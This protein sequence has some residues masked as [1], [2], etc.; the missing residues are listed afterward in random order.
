MLRTGTLQPAAAARA[1]G[2]AATAQRAQRRMRWSLGCATRQLPGL[3]QQTL[4]QRAAAILLVPHCNMLQWATMGYFPAPGVTTSGRRGA[5]RR[6]KRAAPQNP[7]QPAAVRSHVPAHWVALSKS[8]KG[9]QRLRRAAMGQRRMR[10]LC[11]TLQAQRAAPAAPRARGACASSLRHS[12]APSRARAERRPPQRHCLQQTLGAPR[13]PSLARRRLLMRQRQRRVPS[14]RRA[15][16][17]TRP[18]MRRGGRCWQRSGRSAPMAQP[19][20]LCQPPRQQHTRA[21]MHPWAQRAAALAHT[22]RQSWSA[23]RQRALTRLACQ[24]RQSVR[25]RMR[26]AVRRAR[27]VQALH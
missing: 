5:G 27:A 4:A 7:Q 26:A 12:R 18:A 3:M 25:G 1:S 19:Q 24:A 22:R 9:A 20:A 10:A 15:A 8:R 23:P 21:S 16:A 13:A 11:R 6:P 17:L 2:C 14:L